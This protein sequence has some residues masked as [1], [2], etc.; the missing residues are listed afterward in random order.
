MTSQPQT[1]GLAA[2]VR[3]PAEDILRFVAYHLEAGALRIYIYLD[4]ENPAAF[5][6][7][8]AHPKVR[9]TTC[10]TAWWRKQRNGKPVKHQVR[11]TLNATDAYQRKAEVDWLI[12]MDVDEFLVSGQPVAGIL[13]TLPADTRCARVRPMESLAGDVTAFKGFISAGPERDKIVAD[14]YPTYGHLI[15]GGFLSHLAGK[16]FVRTGHPDLTVK[17]HNAFQNGIEIK[18]ADLDQ[19]ILA[20]AHCHARTWED[21]LTAYRYRLAKGSY[22]AELAPNR[23]RIKG[24]MSLHEL[25]ER[26]EERDG[27]PGLRAFFDE[28]CADTP[29]LRA[30][31]DRHGLLRK[32]N[33]RLNAALST[34]FP[35]VTP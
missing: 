3:A 10:D 28:V 20:L 9:V 4:D 33:L 14:I 24:G 13:S 31:L 1:W 27:E 26:I 35:C 21:W 19:D 30:R 17:I 12:H 5:D 34:H 11:Q 15:K 18:G 6:A 2:T 16:V 32:T 25:F 29:D 23:P 8:K 7:L 22:R